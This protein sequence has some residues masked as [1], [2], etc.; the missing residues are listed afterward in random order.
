MSD[1]SPGPVSSEEGMFSPEEPAKYAMSRIKTAAAHTKTMNP[2]LNL[3]I[4]SPN[5][6]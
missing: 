6:T 4:S 3:V 1:V 2:V 5:L